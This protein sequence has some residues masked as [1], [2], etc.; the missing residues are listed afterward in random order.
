MKFRAAAACFMALLFSPH[1]QAVSLE[2]LTLK[3]MAY[4]SDSGVAEEFCEA[5]VR[6]FL[7]GVSMARAS[8]EGASESW[9]ERAARTRLGRPPAR[10]IRK[11]SWCVPEG[12]SLSEIVRHL[13]DYASKHG[14]DAGMPAAEALDSV[15]LQ[16]Y[17]C[18][19]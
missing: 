5:Y 17:P 4:Q 12:T 2:E 11:A 13:L 18:R 3:C 10:V 19:H 16:H 14:S 7:E 8:R 6:G 15:L 1:A 9:T